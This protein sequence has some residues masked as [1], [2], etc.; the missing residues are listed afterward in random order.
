MNISIIVIGDEILLGQVTDT[1]SGMI[2]RVASANGWNINSVT[3]V[4]DDFSVLKD[5]VEKTLGTTDVI[6]TTGGIGPTKDDMTKNVML[7]VFGG[8]MESGCSHSS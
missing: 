4:P 3:V 1:N 6:I 8:K 7:D 2:A 5:T